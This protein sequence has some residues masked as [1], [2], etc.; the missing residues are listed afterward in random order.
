[1]TAT[2]LRIEGRDALF[3]KAQ[4]LRRDVI[5]M[6]HHARSGHP[7]GALGMADIFTVLW[8]RFLRD[9]PA[10]PAWPDRDRFVLSNGHICPILYAVLADRGYF[11]RDLLFTFRKL[12]SRVQG[13]PSIRKDLPGIEYSGGSLG[14]GLSYALGI[15]LAARVSGRPY[16]VFCSLG[17]GDC[18]EGQTWEAAMAAAHY[19]VGN[20]V[21]MVDYNKTQIDGPIDQVMSLGNL[22]DK[23]RAFGWHVQEIDGH[24]HAAV[25]QAFQAALERSDLPSVLVAHTVIGK[26]VSFMEGDYR[27][28]HGYPDEDQ[29]RRA[30][31]ELTV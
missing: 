24:D 23:W 17:D 1:M 26:G 3:A 25:E 16:R 28:H 12:G 22:A 8:Y 10:N 18:Q 14:N 30:M 6:V 7:G 11:Q 9:D 21:A 20:L 15:A 19:R 29:Y 13:H 27:W 4:Q 5:E 2:G 31:A